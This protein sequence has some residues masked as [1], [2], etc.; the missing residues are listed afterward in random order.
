MYPNP[1]TN[2]VNF[3]LDLLTSAKVSIDLT[4]VTGK[5]V[6]QISERTASAGVSE[7]LIDMNGLTAGV[8]VAEL[9][10]DGAAYPQKIV[11]Q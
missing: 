7:I 3:E 6:R 9:K 10:I 5:I 4:D 11:K 2:V 1:V 8:Y